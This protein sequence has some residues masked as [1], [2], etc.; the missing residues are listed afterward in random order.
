MSF[1]NLQ[2]VMVSQGPVQRLLGIADLRVESAGGGGALHDPH[3]LQQDSMHTGVFHG[4]ENAPEI[5]DL[6][7][8]VR[9][10]PFP[11]TGHLR[12]LRQVLGGDC[13]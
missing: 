2:Q 10:V 7:V 5:R 12:A 6:P 1:A 8:E 13:R 9:D 3:G 11:A 4:V